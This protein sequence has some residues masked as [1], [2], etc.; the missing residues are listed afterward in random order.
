MY[1]TK[2]HLLTIFWCLISKY[3]EYDNIFINWSLKFCNKNFQ[4]NAHQVKLWRKLPRK[5]VRRH[6][7]I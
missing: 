3:T 2:T 1:L 4:P 7:N 6:I 5:R